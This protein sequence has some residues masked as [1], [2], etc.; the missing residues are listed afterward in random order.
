MGHLFADDV[1]AYVHD[2]LSAQFIR[3]DRIRALSHDFHPWVTS[4][5]LS[6]KSL[7]SSK[8][9][10]MWFGTLQQLWKLDLLLLAQNFPNLY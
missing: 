3:A 10:P 9:Q 7:N 8:T 4:N 5:R 1:Q 6:L 2:P